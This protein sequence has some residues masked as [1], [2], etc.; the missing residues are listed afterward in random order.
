MWRK[1]MWRLAEVDDPRSLANWFRRRRF[2]RVARFI[3]AT[4]GPRPIRI[5]DVGGTESFWRQSGRL[6]DPDLQIVVL[7][8][9]A[10]E[11]HDPSIECA[12]GSATD[13]SRYAD[14]SFDLAFSNSVIEHVGSWSNQKAMAEE[15]RRV[16]TRY[17]VQTPNLWFPLEP[18]LQFPFFAILPM[19]VRVW[20][21][22][23]IPLGWRDRIPDY[24]EA[25]AR[26]EFFLLL[27]RRQLVALF[28]D[29]QIERERLLGFTKSLM[30]F[31]ESKSA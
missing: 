3:D 11:D 9:T 18:H 10:P 27:S 24:A 25:R 5:L 23:H 7:N 2:A 31:G 16:A 21:L 19:A 17:Y 1:L 22:Q 28:P 26:A 4:P 13:L 14:D 20:L 29:A 8:L 15:I 12:A 6:G 30:V